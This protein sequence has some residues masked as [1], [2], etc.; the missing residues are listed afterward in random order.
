[1]DAFDLLRAQIK[2]EVEA[3]GASLSA[4]NAKDYAEYQYLCGKI[5]GLLIAQD[6]IIDLKERMET[7]DD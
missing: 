6:L 3:M 1:M 5:R 7:S 4:G 2:E